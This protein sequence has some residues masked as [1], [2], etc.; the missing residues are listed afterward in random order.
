[1]N[2]IKKD[3]AGVMTVAVITVRNGEIIKGKQFTSQAASYRFC[4]QRNWRAHDNA[5]RKC[6]LMIRTM[7]EKET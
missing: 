5:G 7:R 6:Q 4:V 2:S 1:M 3:D